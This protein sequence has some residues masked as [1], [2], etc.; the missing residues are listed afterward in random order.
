MS[1]HSSSRQSPSK[2]VLWVTLLAACAIVM[3]GMAK[4]YQRFV[5]PDHPKRHILVIMS[6]TEGLKSYERYDE[7]LRRSLSREHVNAR[8]DYF[9]LDCERFNEQD[10][11]ARMDSVVNSYTN[12]NWPDLI[13]VNGDQATY[14]LLSTYNDRLHRIRIVFGAVRFP[15]W[16]LL[17]KYAPDRNITGLYDSID[18][19]G[20]LRF[21]YKLTRRGTIVTQIDD[22][23]LDRQTV[24]MVDSQLNPRRDVINNIHWRVSL[25][26][27]R[28]YNDSL[29]LCSISLRHTER[30]ASDGEV[31]SRLRKSH[32]NYSLDDEGTVADRKMQGSINYGTIM[33]NTNFTH[34]LLKNESGANY[35]YTL[36]HDHI[37][38]AID[39][40]FCTGE[41]SKVI[42]GYMTTWE[43]TAAEEARLA[44]SI[45]VDNISPADLPIT[46]PKKDY[47]MDWTARGIYGNSDAF[48]DIPPYVKIYNRPFS[49]AHPRA[50]KALQALSLMLTVSIIILL[51]S[52]YRREQRRKKKALA[53]LI[54]ERE[55]LRLAIRGSETYAWVIR[56]GVI[57]LQNEFF[58]KMGQPFRIYSL[59]A[60]GLAEFVLPGYIDGIKRLLA[61]Q[62]EL[63]QYTYQCEMDFGTGQSRWWE[64]RSTTLRTLSGQKKVLGLLLDISEFMRRE[65]ALEKAKEE[66]IE[67]ER[68]AEE[69]RRLAQEAELKQSFLANMSHEIRTPLN[70][71]VGFSNL[72]VTQLDE[73]SADEQRM[74]VQNI[75]HNSEL[76]LRLV[77]DVLEI[78]RIESG[79]MKFDFQTISVDDV[80]DNVYQANRLQIPKHLRFFV[81]RGQK[82]LALFVDDG[83]LLQVLTNFITNAGKFTPQ[84]SITLGWDY[85]EATKEV[86]LYVEDTGIGLSA[87]EQKLVFSRFYKADE[88]KQGTGLGLSISK[89]IVERLHG[90]IELKSEV[91]K[92][93]R[94][95]VVLTAAKEASQATEDKIVPVAD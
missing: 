72:L 65:A 90:R 12:G 6:N 69:A 28:H 53:D 56:D 60:E 13:I 95:S 46:V 33:S 20:N 84:G 24:A 43:T 83:R 94:F 17:A 29:A 25:L 32:V 82:G 48:S 86:E 76:L 47:V 14:S 79:Y 71:I 4:C 35:H 41:K 3:A 73:L 1:S 9:Y 77:N 40:R 44:R 16:K 63:G 30:N 15:N 34:L 22:S 92:G 36:A 19:M 45:L 23:Y 27:M 21:I 51:F 91:G 67:N 89:V 87:A 61:R 80:I 74:F 49:E 38:S 7:A 68:L 75:N 55:N 59:T 64:I 2:A 62:Q 70:A 66:A 42:G 8:L 10:E 31:L 52:L 50:T 88:F 57:V 26:Y 39:E 37:F 81:H 85:R 93:S 11:I 54:E 18:V 58:T 78:S 5:T